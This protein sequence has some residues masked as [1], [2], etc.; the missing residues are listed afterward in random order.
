[1]TAD[2]GSRAVRPVVSTPG[3]Y[4]EASFSPDGQW[5]AYRKAGTDGTRT[6]AGTAE[7]GL[8]VAAADGSA[9]SRLVRE[10]GV[11][12]QFDHTGTRLYFREQRAQFVL[13]SVD[14]NGADEIVHAQSAN[15]TDIVPSPDGKWIAFHERWR[16]YVMPFARTGRPVDIGPTVRGMPV[17]QV[18]RDA[19]FFLHWSADSRRVY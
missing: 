7:T 12:P 6:D 13:A 3:H 19:G 18:S 4:I 16:L 8:Y 14:L 2:V 9:A 11:E 1:V 17:A 15:A 10:N 5:I